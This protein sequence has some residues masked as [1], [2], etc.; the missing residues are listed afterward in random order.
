[1][2]ILVSFLPILAWSLFEQWIGRGPALAI[3]LGLGLGISA[4]RWRRGGLM[5]FDLVV[6][7]VVLAVGLSE[8][9]WPA[10]LEPWSGVLVNGALA[11]YVAGSVAVGKPYT[12]AYARA[13]TDPQYWGGPVF[14]RINRDISIGWAVL[15]ALLAVL[16]RFRAEVFAAGSPVPTLLT[17]AVIAGAVAVS[18]RYG[19]WA[20]ARAAAAA[21]GQ[22]PPDA[23]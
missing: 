17:V 16:Q 12:A 19:D 9:I 8:S 2:G 23:D 11:A 6:L 21:N 10:A 20:G 3:G 22:K 14:H 1:M 5:P 18:E 15:F 7:G 13:R 4:Y